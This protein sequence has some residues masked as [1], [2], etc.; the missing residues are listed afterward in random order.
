MSQAAAVVEL[1]DLGALEEGRVVEGHDS[2]VGDRAQEALLYLAGQSQAGLQ[3]PAEDAPGPLGQPLLQRWSGEGGA[4]VLLDGGRRPETPVGPLVAGLVAC[5][6]GH[7]L[8]LYLLQSFSLIGP[9]QVDVLLYRA[10]I[11][12]FHHV[13]VSN[14]RTRNS[15]RQ[16][17]EMLC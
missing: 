5:H 1:I 16:S 8:S 9:A 10:G 14:N 4:H 17:S 11:F 3:L 6:A 7:E 15:S 13:G 12:G 2:L